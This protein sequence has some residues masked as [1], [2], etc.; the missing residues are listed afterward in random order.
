V[1][2]SRDLKLQ[3]AL[4]IIRAESLERI[5][6]LVHGFSTRQGGFSKAYGGNA[7]N[8]GFG[9]GDS[10]MNVERNRRSLRSALGS[11][12]RYREWPMVNLRQIHSDIIRPIS[13]IPES[14]LSGDGLITELPTIFLAVLAADCLPLILADTK[15]RAVGVFHAGWRGTLKRIAEKGAGEMQRS[16]GTRPHELRAAIGP[17][18]RGCCY[19]VGCEV[20]EAFEAQFSYAGKL[21]R[22]SKES[23]TLERKYPSLFPAALT[24]GQPQPGGR[25]FLDLAESNRR[26][27]LAAGIP[28]ENIS[29]VAMCTSC[30]ADLFFSHRRDDGVTGRMMAVVGIKSRS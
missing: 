27:L 30:R 2:I 21:F 14:V 19:E 3:S 18:I 20:K 17:S 22:E 10:R 8:L 15:R 29:D 16:F 26:Q 4:E 5:P 12:R 9:A 23:N 11:D 6:W 24:R 1:T 7:L 13:E 28:P 25:V